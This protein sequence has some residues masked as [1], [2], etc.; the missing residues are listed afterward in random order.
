ML[1]PGRLKRILLHLRH[2]DDPLLPSLVGLIRGCVS[3]IGRLVVVLGYVFGLSGF[4]LAVGYAL[5]CKTSTFSC[6]GY[7]GI[8][9]LH[10]SLFVGDIGP[11]GKRYEI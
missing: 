6:F 10:L 3:D 2:L 11:I 9:A 7:G 8:G 1:E 4:D 5:E